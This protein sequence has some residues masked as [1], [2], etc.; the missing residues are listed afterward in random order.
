M[1]PRHCLWDGLPLFSGEPNIWAS[2]DED[3]QEQICTALAVLLLAYIGHPD[4]N[5]PILD[6]L[7][8][9]LTDGR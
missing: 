4:P 6:T 7:R 2:L 3:I 5:P 1:S 9:E 8:K